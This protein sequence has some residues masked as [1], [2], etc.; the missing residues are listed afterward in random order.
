MVLLEIHEKFKG[1]FLNELRVSFNNNSGFSFLFPTLLTNLLIQAITLHNLFNKLN[2]L[3]SVMSS[4]VLFTNKVLIS[5]NKCSS[6]TEF[7]IGSSCTIKL[8]SF[9]KFGPSHYKMFSLKLSIALLRVSKSA[10]LLEDSQ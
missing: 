8:P 6:E 7:S 4:L 1:H 2:L 5:L 10:G 3:L 9:S